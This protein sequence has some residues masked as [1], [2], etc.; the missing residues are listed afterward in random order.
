MKSLPTV[1][2]FFLLITSFT[3]SGADWDE[4]VSHPAYIPQ[5]HEFEIPQ[6]EP[7]QEGKFDLKVMNRYWEYDGQVME[8]VTI[9]AEIYMKVD[10]EGS[11][12]IEQIREDVRPHISDK[13][14]TFE[15]N[16]EC[17]NFNSKQE[18]S[19]EIERLGPNETVHL[20]FTIDTEKDTSEGTYF[21]RFA[22]EFEHNETKRDMLSRGF[23]TQEEWNHAIIDA[24]E[25]PGNIN[26]TSLGVSG[27][28]PDSS[29]SVRSPMSQWPLYT[30]ITL[31]VVFASLSILFY[32]EERG[33]H[34]KLNKWLQQ[35]RGKLNHLWF[36]FKNSKGN[37]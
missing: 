35:K 27:I 8:N 2:L 30:I 25:Y 19:F 23:W 3:S 4:Y 24:E 10:G 33:E 15:G 29:F 5:L 34:P 17:E 20:S 36:Y 21:V 28:I 31:T 37:G 26:L 6:I 9:K 12:Y 11:K 18:V 14:I 13:C 1:L 7:G 32:I 16:E 22:I